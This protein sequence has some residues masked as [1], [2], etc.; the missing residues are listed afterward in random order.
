M[1]SPYKRRI[2]RDLDRWQ[3]MGWVSGES[4]AAILA[5]VEASGREFGLAPALGVIASI[6][7]GFAAISFV[8]AHWQEMPRLGRLML[9]LATIW[10]GYGAAGWL[11][12]RGLAQFADA[13][14]LFAVGMFGASIMLISQMYNIGGDPADGVLMWWIGALF[15]G[16]ALRSNPALALAMILVCLWSF[17]ETSQ[18]HAVHWAFLIG[19]FM[20]TAAFIWQRWQPGFH[21]SA[22]TLA[23]FV[24]SL[25]YQLDDGHQHDLVVLIGVIAAGA[26]V[27]LEKFRPDVDAALGHFAS[28]SFAYALAVALAGLFALQFFETPPLGKLIA[29]A[30]V[31]LI[32]ILAGIAYALSTGNRGALWIGYIGFSAEILTLYGVTIGTIL[33]TS[34]FFLIAAMIV[35]L[36]AYVALRLARQSAST[37][38]PA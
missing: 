31:A 27:A 33:G 29:L 11:N 5:D 10:S 32:L 24:V 9:L 35:S 12:T 37:G 19:W 7:F 34:L 30:A 3:S 28:P 23:A 18:R 26:A 4:R 16:I 38:R 22:L 36:L 17:F 20:V 6:L 2:K 8:A 1:W 15:A 14:I 13:A 21:L 25:G